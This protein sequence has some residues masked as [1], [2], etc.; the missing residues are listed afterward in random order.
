MKDRLEKYFF[1]PC[2]YF[3]SLCF[4]CYHGMQ[5]IFIRLM[6]MLTFS[7]EVDAER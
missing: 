1:L 3:S 4:I 5:T 7:T 6:I 2:I